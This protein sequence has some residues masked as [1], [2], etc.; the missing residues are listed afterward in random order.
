MGRLGGGKLAAS[1]GPGL[2]H[3]PAEI[4]T[5]NGDFRITSLSHEDK[6]LFLK[7][8][9]RLK[10]TFDFYRICVLISN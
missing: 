9:L 10:V 2:H 5:R 1:S 8:G 4:N 7:C 3:Q 6:S